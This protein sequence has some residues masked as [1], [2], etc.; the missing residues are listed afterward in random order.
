MKDEAL[1]A[2][3]RRE[4][5]D[6]VPSTNAIA[7]Q[8]AG[9]GDPGGLWVTA[10]EQTAG[11]GRRGR[12]WT[13]G[14][15][16]LAASLLLIDPAEAAVAPTVSFVA[17][18]ALHRSVIDLAGPGVLDRLKLKWP[19][20]LIL[21][22]KKIV[23]ILVEGQTS[24]RGLVMTI[25]MGVNCVSHPPVTTGAYRAGDLAELGLDI[26][27][28]RLFGRLAFNMA[29]ELAVWNR[30]SGFGA[31]RAAWLERALGIGQPITVNLADRSLSGRFQN[32]DADGQLVLELTGGGQRTI[33]AGELFLA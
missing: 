24:E 23:G 16:N 5:H 4:H 17:G 15:G 29:D 7:L 9:E 14:R 30:G 25:G 18:L 11:R 28:D 3:Y 8:R 19:N 26:D 27:A 20:D 2:G 6:S 1:P 21:D 33:A 13:T 31:T 32:L 12:H 10:G 22:G